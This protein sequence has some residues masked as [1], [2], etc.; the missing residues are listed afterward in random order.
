MALKRTAAHPW[1][2]ERC[3]ILLHAVVDPL[4]P[5]KS[6]LLLISISSPMSRGW[7]GTHQAAGESLHS[8]ICG[9][10]LMEPQA[11]PV[12]L[13][14]LYGNCS[15]QLPHF[16]E[17]LPQWLSGPSLVLPA[18][19]DRPPDTKPGFKQCSD[20]LQFLFNYGMG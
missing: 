16:I 4:R 7:L 8:R 10:L 9:P 3:S 11:A 14:Q 18:A 20:L 2:Q 1:A 12:E 6:V 13:L 5:S 17:K 19:T 15:S